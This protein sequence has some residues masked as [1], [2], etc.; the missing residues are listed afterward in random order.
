MS[1][2]SNVVLPLAELE[3]VSPRVPKIMIKYVHKF[4][5]VNRWGYDLNKNLVNI[6]FT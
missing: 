1:A 5:H 3:S 6:M 2:D 4:N